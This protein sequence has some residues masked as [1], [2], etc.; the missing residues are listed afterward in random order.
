MSLVVLV[1][2]LLV[3]KLLTSSIPKSST[4]LNTS[5]LKSLENA[6]AM[7][8]AKYPTITELIKL[9]SAHANMYAPCSSISDILLP[10]VCTNFV[11]S[12]I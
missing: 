2:K 12:D 11:I 10:S 6:A 7:F 8:A 5:F 3:E 9:P 4:F 1:I